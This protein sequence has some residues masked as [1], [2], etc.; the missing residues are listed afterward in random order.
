MR[1]FGLS[2]E[3]I[4]E[5]SKKNKEPSWMLKKRLLGYKIFKKKVLPDWGPDL[6]E[7]NLDKI[8]YFKESLGKKNSNKWEDV[9]KEIR[10]VY[11]RLGIPK[12]EKESL[13]GVGAQY[14]SSIV[15]HNLKKE[16]EKKGVVFLSCGDALKKESKLMKKYFMTSCVPIG[17]HKFSALHAA[18]WSGGTFIYIPKNTKVELPL[19]A[20]F[21]MNERSGGQFEHTLIIVD[22]GSDL[23]YIEG[24]SAPKNQE[25]SLHVGCVEIFVMKNAKMKYSS[26]ENWSKNVYN[27]NTKRAI[28]EEN[29]KISWVNGNLGSKKTMLYPS[30]FLIGENS[31]SDYLGITYAGKGQFQDTGC[32]VYHL[33]P[34]TKSYI[35]SKSISKDGG[36]SSYRGLVKISR[37]AVD[38]VTSVSCEGLLLDKKSVSKTFP[39]MEIKENKVLANHEAKIG[40][41]DQEQLFY[42]KSRGLNEEESIKLII[43]GYIEPIVKKLPLE[44]AVELNKLIDIEIEKELNKK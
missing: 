30:S 24:C 8:K 40:S 26:I 22:E 41:I 35:L 6:S 3:L 9:P 28:V 42:L 12:A 36:I 38:S 21:R 11:E 5:I 44:Y 31:R 33:A 4:R 37:G 7:L 32:K 25:S 34:R 29:G 23:H 2:E 39:S 15:Y 14:D 17:L 20:Y 18:V 27:L 43:A 13:G 16:L 1:K 19:Q 10:E